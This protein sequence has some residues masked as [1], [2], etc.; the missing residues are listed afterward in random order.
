MR[1]ITLLLAFLA[2]KIITGQTYFY[3]DQIAV[4]PPAPTTAD[5]VSIQ[6]IGNLSSSGSYI[7]SAEASMNGSL[8][9]LTIVAASTGG[10]T[11]LVPHTEAI[12]IGQLPAGDYTIAFTLGSSGILDSAPAQQHTFT[13][14]GQGG[15]PC[16][17]V[18]IPS[19]RWHA[20]SDTA[21][22]VHVVNNSTEGFSYPNFILF[23]SNGDTLAKETVNFFGIAQESWHFLRVME[24]VI[25][26]SMPINGTLELWTLFTEELA[27][28][29]SMSID[30]CPPETCSTFMPSMGNYG[31]ALVL[32]TFNWSVSDGSG[33]IANGQFEMTASDQY[34]SANLC[35]PPGEYQMDVS[36]TGPPT[37]GGP[38][39]FATD[40]S[41]YGTELWPVAW[42]LPVSLPVHFYAPCIDGTNAVEEAP[43]S[44]FNVRRIPNGLLMERMDGRAIGPV[45]LFD[46]QGRLVYEAS[47]LT[48]RLVVPLSTM[49]VH[50]LRMED[51]V[52]KVMTGIE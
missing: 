17:D 8:V 29:W 40:E 18:L 15:D 47:G 26:P 4:V 12:A 16:D 32:G 51:A 36:P 1:H 41:G 6:L 24:G 14:T 38:M 5:D 48:D 33:T 21:I 11:V 10:L 46:P 2:A 43:E 42:S 30:L 37:G 23:D 49:G 28:S 13:V 50:V 34:V 3:I 45:H 52:L 9:A 20:F 35:L 39:F 31:G 27:C 44:L 22:V 19:V 7:V 25:M